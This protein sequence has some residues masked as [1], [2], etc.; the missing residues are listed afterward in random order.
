LATLR[1]AKIPEAELALR[2]VN[3]VK[4]RGY[5]SYCSLIDSVAVAAIIDPT[6]ITTEELGCDV[7]RRG[8]LTRGMTVVER[9]SHHGR[10]DLPRVSAVNGVEF[11]RF[12]DLV[13]GVLSA[14]AA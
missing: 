12:L 13:T 8:E 9:R 7:E 1:E 5:Q 11:D 6:L 14:H 2:V 4:G 3:F 10:T